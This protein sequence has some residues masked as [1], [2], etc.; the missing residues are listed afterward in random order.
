MQPTLDEATMFEA[1]HEGD[2]LSSAF[3]SMEADAATFV[4]GDRVVV[5]EGELKNM[6]GVVLK[7]DKDQVLIKPLDEVM[8]GIAE[9]PLAP[10]Q[11]RKFFKISDHVKVNNGRFAGETGLVVKVEDSHVSVLSDLTMKVRVGDVKSGFLYYERGFPYYN[12]VIAC[13]SSFS[14]FFSWQEIH[15]LAK[16]LEICE[17]VGTGLDSLGNYQL[18]DLVQINNSADVGCI[19]RIERDQLKVCLVGTVKS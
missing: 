16:D 2:G 11:L 19:V 1:A 14:F 13:S 9:V 15:V 5:R 17:I 4:V 10:Q 18:F 12:S 3:R 7:I 6:Q 8:S